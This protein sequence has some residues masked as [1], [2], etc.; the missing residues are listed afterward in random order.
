M[1][2][3]V[4]T[5]AKRRRA[6]SAAA[7]LG[8]IGFA[9]PAQPGLAAANAD[10]LDR[11]KALCQAVEQSLLDWRWLDKLRNR[12]IMLADCL[13]WE[14]L[15]AARSELVGA[16]AAKAAEVAAAIPGV[17]SSTVEVGPDWLPFGSRPRLQSRITIEVVDEGS[18]PP[19]AT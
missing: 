15:D 11:L 9:A 2:G 6:R 16:D 14:E 18:Q 19:G 5:S 17:A 12:R 13:L 10:V 4:W 7:V 3:K 8:A 1:P